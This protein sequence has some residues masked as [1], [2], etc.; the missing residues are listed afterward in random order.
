MDVQKRRVWD[1]RALELT[2]E[3]FAGQF[4][5]A[6]DT[7]IYRW[8]SKGEPMA[9][10]DWDRDALIQEFNRR[11]YKLY[12]ALNILTLVV[13]MVLWIVFMR[14]SQESMILPHLRLTLIWG[15][16]V[17]GPIFLGYFL[18]LRWIW[19]AP[20]RLIAQWGRTL[21]AECVLR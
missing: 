3:A 6:G 1:N 9:L 16:I 17:L 13:T 14:V 8:R 19:D 11:L 4:E 21:D 7:I 2:R 20:R 15:A 18:V 12:L 5:Q 10:T